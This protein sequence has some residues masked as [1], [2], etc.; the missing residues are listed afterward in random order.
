MFDRYNIT[1][2]RDLAAAAVAIGKRFEA[3][4]S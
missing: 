1:D 2:E 3:P 4:V